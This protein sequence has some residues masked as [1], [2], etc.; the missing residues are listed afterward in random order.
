[1]R[2]FLATCFAIV[3]ALRS[4]GAVTAARESSLSRGVR[5]Y[6]YDRR[7]TVAIAASPVGNFLHGSDE[8]NDLRVANRVASSGGPWPLN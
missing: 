7:E 4:D 1:V 6:I 3:S 8:E 2:A 5:R